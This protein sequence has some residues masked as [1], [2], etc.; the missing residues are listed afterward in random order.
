MQHI[1]FLLYNDESPAS[2]PASLVPSVSS[3]SV[4]VQVVVSWTVD[5]N[6]NLPLS[7]YTSLFSI[8]SRKTSLKVLSLVSIVFQRW[9]AGTLELNFSLFYTKGE[10]KCCSHWSSEGDDGELECFVLFVYGSVWFGYTLS[11]P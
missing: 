5:R 8:S 2:F 10:R 6:Y 4:F 1:C 7:R 11:L 9:V 3:D